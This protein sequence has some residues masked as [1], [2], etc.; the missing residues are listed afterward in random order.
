[1]Y[2]KKLS[3]LNKL[4]IQAFIAVGPRQLSEVVYGIAI[5]KDIL[6]SFHQEI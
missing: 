2:E 6:D 1:M 5:N 4:F 3:L